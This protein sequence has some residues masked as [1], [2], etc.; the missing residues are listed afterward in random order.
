MSHSVP[1]LVFT[2]SNSSTFISFKC[3]YHNKT[4]IPILFDG[5]GH[6]S[7]ID[8]LLVVGI[9]TLQFVKSL[10]YPHIAGVETLNIDGCNILF[11]TVG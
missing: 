1:I 4:F 3:K 8:L 11:N 7:Q 10:C 2:L 6:H 9:L 5:N